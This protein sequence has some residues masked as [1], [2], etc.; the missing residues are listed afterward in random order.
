MNSLL[1]QD[2][3]SRKRQLQVRTYSV[4]PL[5]EKGGVIEWVPDVLP[6][7]S[8]IRK[9]HNQ[10]GKSEDEIKRKQIFNDKNSLDK[11]LITLK[12][13]QDNLPPVFSEFLRFV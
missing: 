1:L 4:I 11:Q 13:C 3:E 7:R 2:S 12:W 9:I 10:M 5:Q 8:C 6:I